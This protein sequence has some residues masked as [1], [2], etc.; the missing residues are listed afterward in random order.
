MCAQGMV[1]LH[2]ANLREATLATWARTQNAR[3]TLRDSFWRAGATRDDS[4]NHD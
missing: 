4:D 2:R 3:A 1:L